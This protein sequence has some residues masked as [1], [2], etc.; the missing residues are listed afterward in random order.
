VENEARL[1]EA[2]LVP[3]SYIYP[4]GEDHEDD[5]VT[6]NVRSVGLDTGRNIILAPG[7]ANIVTG[8]K[9]LPKDMT[10]KIPWPPTLAN[11]INKQKATLPQAETVNHQPAMSRRT[12]TPPPSHHL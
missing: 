4:D 11:E 9:A 12:S 7:A 8:A 3:D 2:L 10:N 6:E 5:A 1:E